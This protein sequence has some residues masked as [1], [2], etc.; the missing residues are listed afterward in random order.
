M[1]IRLLTLEDNSAF[2]QVRLQA[3]RDEPRAFGSSYEDTLTIPEAEKEKT[4]ANRIAGPDNFVMGAF[5]A[6]KLVGIAGF[7]R[8]TGPKERHRAMLWGMYIAPEA[9]HS[10]T[11]QALLTGLVEQ[12]GK[13]EGVEQIHLGVVTVQEA[14]FKLYRRVGFEVYG[15]EPRALRIGPDYFDETLM[16]LRLN[17]T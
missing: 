8:N 15:I 11:G 14:A 16:V 12:A 9:R 3:L 13:V 17:H 4:F 5:E 1:E 2:W 10:G 7:F 6:G